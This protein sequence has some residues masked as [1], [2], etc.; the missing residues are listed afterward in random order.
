ME[1]KKAVLAESAS[2]TRVCIRLAVR[3]EPTLRMT[4]RSAGRMASSLLVPT[5]ARLGCS[6]A[7]NGMMMC[8]RVSDP[9]DPSSP[10]AEVDRSN[11]VR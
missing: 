6:D 4:A 10:E 9:R 2:S 5:I 3:T 11:D 8:E 7:K 1:D